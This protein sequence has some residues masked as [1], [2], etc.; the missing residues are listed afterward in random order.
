MFRGFKPDELRALQPGQRVLLLGTDTNGDYLFATLPVLAN[1]SDCV[2]L[3]LK[4]LEE[5]PDAPTWRRL[6]RQGRYITRSNTE[7]DKPVTFAKSTGLRIDFVNMQIGCMDITGEGLAEL[8]RENLEEK[9]KRNG[10]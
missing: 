9:R 4:P 10:N 2:V 3:S 1:R 5:S 8:Q 7:F 6:V